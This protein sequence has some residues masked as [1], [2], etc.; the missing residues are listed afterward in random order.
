MQ[1]IK[2]RAVRFDVDF[3][4]RDLRSYDEFRNSNKFPG[5]LRR[6]EAYLFVSRSG[7]QLL[8]VLNVSQVEVSRPNRLGQYQRRIIDT[9]RWRIEGGTWNPMMLQ[10]YAN[11][12]DLDLVGFRRYEDQYLSHKGPIL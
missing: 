2:L 9:R 11:E 3:R 12:V 8:W 10:N 4:L 5:E 6:N 7:D 1:S